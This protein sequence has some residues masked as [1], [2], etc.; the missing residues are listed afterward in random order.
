MASDKAERSP[1]RLGRYLMVLYDWSSS[2]RAALHRAAATTDV[3]AQGYKQTQQ[4]L[5]LPS[6]ANTHH[7][8]K[9][10]KPCITSK[11]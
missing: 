6:H 2:P 3:E 9:H 10:K 8:Q 4:L 11:A 5:M 7:T 1:P